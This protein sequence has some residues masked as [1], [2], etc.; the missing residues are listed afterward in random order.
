MTFFVQENYPRP[1]EAGSLVLPER[2]KSRETRSKLNC[3]MNQ[4][5]QS[6]DLYKYKVEKKRRL[7]RHV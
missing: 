5:M 4:G 2:K 1:V 6:G 3:L 7:N